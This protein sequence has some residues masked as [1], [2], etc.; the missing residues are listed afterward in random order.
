V[1][2]LRTPQAKRMF[3]KLA[4]PLAAGIK[5]TL[6]FK[7]NNHGQPTDP[8][9]PLLQERYIYA[10]WH[11]SLLGILALR[12]C[13]EVCPLISQSN[14]GE[15]LSD[16][17]EWFGL[18][19]IR[20]SS[21][22]GGTEAAQE[23]IAD[24]ANSHLLIAPDGPKGPRREVKRGVSYLASWSG[25]PVVPLGLSFTWA[26]RLKTWDRLQIPLPFSTVTLVAGPIL[27]VPEAVNKKQSEEFR[28]ELERRIN[29]AQKEACE[30]AGQPFESSG[31]AS[32]PPTV[33]QAA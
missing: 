21:T 8:W 24:T 6:R 22:R 31:P 5:R 16:L 30:W 20:G 13:A 32:M 26:L 10:L 29:A 7:S 17:C 9:N 27:H 3:G 33:R 2:W 28:A 18:R 12:S 19:P 1:K 23:V 25:K 4:V 15:I 11:E 14:D